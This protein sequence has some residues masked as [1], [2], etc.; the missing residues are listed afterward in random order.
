MDKI[1]NIFKKIRSRKCFKII[2]KTAHIL[3]FLMG[4]LLILLL[5]IDTIAL[6]KERNFWKTFPC[7]EEYTDGSEDIEKRVMDLAYFNRYYKD[8]D[9]DMSNIEYYK[10]RQRFLKYKNCEHKPKDIDASVEF[11]RNYYNTIDNRPEFEDYTID[12]ED[13]TRKIY[14]VPERPDL[15]PFGV[16]AGHYFLEVSED[17]KNLAIF[18]INTKTEAKTNIEVNYSIDFRHDSK[19]LIVDKIDSP[20]RPQDEEDMDDYIHEK[21]YVL[22]EEGKGF[23]QL[24]E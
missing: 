22:D 12:D 4:L 2:F 1:K 20:E 21:Y 19:L 3:I 6:I 17:S 11:M 7:P 14:E 24:T 10:N 9:P 23:Y 16:F 15:E 18:D 5:L 13:V 8:L